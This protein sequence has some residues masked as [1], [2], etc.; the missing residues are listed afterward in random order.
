MD[1]SKVLKTAR[2][3]NPDNQIL[4]CL[5]GDIQSELGSIAFKG[6][7]Y[8]SAKSKYRK[9]IEEYKNALKGDEVE[10]ITYAQKAIERVKIE[11]KKIKEAEWWD[12]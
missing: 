7:N 8:S 9:A 3:I 11:L 2:Q 6:K 4:Y 1:A 5:A 10:W 12:R